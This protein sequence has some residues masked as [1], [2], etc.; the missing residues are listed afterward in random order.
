M[1]FEY[2]NHGLVVYEKQEK[3]R[4]VSQENCDSQSFRF[5]SPLHNHMESND[6]FFFDELDIMEQPRKQYRFS[7][8]K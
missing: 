4:V 7:R 5:E 8:S 3:K 2:D 1:G 6:S